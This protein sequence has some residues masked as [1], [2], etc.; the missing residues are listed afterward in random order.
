MA[1]RLAPTYGRG[2][3]S[4]PN[5]PPYVVVVLWMM[6]RFLAKTSHYTSPLLRPRESRPKMTK[7]F[8]HQQSFQQV[9]R[10]NK[11]E[12]RHLRK[13]LLLLV[14]PE[15]TVVLVVGDLSRA[16][17]MYIFFQ[18]LKP[19][20]ADDVRNVKK[21]SIIEGVSVERTQQKNNDAGIFVCARECQ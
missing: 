18:C 3:R 8:P 14:R 6:I 2:E 1:S 12:S 7:Y 16:E 11:T 19:S 17:C 13:R 9:W 21:V 10:P 5:Q 15:T 4:D 20:V